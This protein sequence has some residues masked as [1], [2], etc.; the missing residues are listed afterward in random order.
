MLLRVRFHAFV[1]QPLSK[2]LYIPRVSLRDA[3]LLVMFIPIW[4]R[5]RTARLLFQHG[6]GL[7]ALVRPD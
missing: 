2:Q 1:G 5:L 7:G 3:H 4:R 6:I